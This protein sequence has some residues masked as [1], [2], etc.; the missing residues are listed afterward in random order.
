MNRSY[1][2]FCAIAERVRV[3]L[4]IRHELGKQNQGHQ[5]AGKSQESEDN[6]KEPPQDA[7]RR[8]PTFLNHL[9]TFP[10]FQHFLE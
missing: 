2:Y 9:K 10:T 5:Q 4:Q 8:G 6:K 3:G 1:C 7:L